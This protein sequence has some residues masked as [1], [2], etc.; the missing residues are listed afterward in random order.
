MA[1]GFNAPIS[2]VF[3]AVET[4][5]Q[6][7]GNKSTGE[8]SEGVTIAAVLLACLASSIAS[9][10]GLGAVP[11]FRVPNYRIQSLYEMPLVLLLGALG[12]CV[13]SAMVYSSQVSSPDDSWV[14]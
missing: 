14:A 10:A 2:G 11:A 6:K 5:L 13:S 8:N 3:F 9:Q 1:A 12:G 4:V 7:R